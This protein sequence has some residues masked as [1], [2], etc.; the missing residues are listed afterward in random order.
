MFT[1][2]VDGD[3]LCLSSYGCVYLWH[4]GACI[5]VIIYKKPKRI[6]DIRFGFLSYSNGKNT[7]FNSSLSLLIA[8]TVF[9]YVPKA[10]SLN[11]PA[12]FFPKPSPGVPTT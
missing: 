7:Y 2:G 6:C 9:S 3:N 12:P 1:Y 10:V 4:N 8:S 11:Q 5:E